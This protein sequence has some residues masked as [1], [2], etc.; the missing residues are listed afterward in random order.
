MAIGAGTRGASV[1]AARGAS[2][3]SGVVGGVAGST[4]GAGTALTAAR[5]AR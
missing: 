4:A 5:S 2:I 1:V 3:E